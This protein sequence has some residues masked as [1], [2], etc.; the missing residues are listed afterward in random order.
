[1][2]SL[3]SIQR[4]TAAAVTLATPH[5]PG[6][7]AVR[8]TQV[9]RRFGD[10][11]AVHD[12]TMDVPAG[13]VTVLLGPN[14]AGKSTTVRLMTGS[15]AADT[16]RVEVFGLDPIADGTAV[17][18]RCGVVPPKPS[19][20]LRMSGR[21]NLR[22]AAEIYGLGRR[23]A[24]DFLIDEAADRFG[25]GHALAQKVDGYS[26]GMRTRLALA[27]AVLHDPDL[28]LLD[29]P[30]AGLDPESARAVLGLIREMAVRGKTVVVCTHLLHE[31]EGLADQVVLVS[32]G[33]AVA[34]GPPHE[35]ARRLWP[36][37]RLVLEAEQPAR[38]DAVAAMDGV[39]AY[40]RNGVAT[41]DLDDPARIPE[42]V[43]RLVDDGVRLT[44]VQPLQPTLE[45][46]YFALQR[47]GNDQPHP[48]DGPL[49]A[50]P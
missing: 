35:L 41:A 32:R 40:H 17:R 18:Q 13:T 8:L 30:T 20:Y 16:G 36:D 15:I 1:M 33:T 2:T 23:A 9:G 25:I 42:L 11:V 29:E 28:L 19:L 22:Y 3:E 46:L 4:D 12:M 39:L 6:T 47:D 44:R 27:R 10:V 14:G 21:D 34:A 45:E 43:R 49:V 26:T 38:L 37:C 7:T 24:A 5:A 48:H 50:A 31:A